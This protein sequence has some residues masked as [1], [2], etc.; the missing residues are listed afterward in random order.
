MTVQ[1]QPWAPA[2]SFLPF[3]ATLALTSEFSFLCFSLPSGVTIR[4][5]LSGS[6]PCLRGR[7]QRTEMDTRSL[8]ISAHTQPHM[9]T[10]TDVGSSQQKQPPPCD[11]PALKQAMLL[12]EKMRRFKSLGGK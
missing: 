9:C 3:P 12:P 4:W 2:M 8:P 6:R 7:A 1:G 11:L 5:W 10:H